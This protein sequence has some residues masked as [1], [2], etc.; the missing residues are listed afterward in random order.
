M[1]QSSSSSSKQKSAHQEPSATS[2]S[3]AAAH[4]KIYAQLTQAVSTP[5]AFLTKTRLVSS[6]MSG[7]KRPKLA[8]PQQQTLY[9]TPQQ[10]IESSSALNDIVGDLIT[11]QNMMPS[12]NESIS[13]PSPPIASKNA[14]QLRNAAMSSSNLGAGGANQVNFEL[15][16]DINSEMIDKLFNQYSFDAFTQQQKKRIITT[17]LFQNCFRSVFRFFFEPYKLLYPKFQL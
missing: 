11:L 16:D 12:S 6:D 7:S 8:A 15:E 13:S 17:F 3:S 9:S 2:S 10:L 1:K 14:Q 5:P 4:Q